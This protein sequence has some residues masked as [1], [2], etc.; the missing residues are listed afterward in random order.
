MTYIMTLKTLLH[1]EKAMQRQKEVIKDIA[2]ALQ[3]IAA[4]HRQ[5]MIKPYQWVCR[6]SVISQSLITRSS[7]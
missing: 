1:G 7:N 6:L 2:G 4:Y 3:F 5:P